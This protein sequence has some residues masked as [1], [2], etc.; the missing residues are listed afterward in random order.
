MLEVVPSDR[1]YLSVRTAHTLRTSEHIRNPLSPIN[2]LVAL[3]QR[4]KPPLTL[5]LLACFTLRN[6]YVWSRNSWRIYIVHTHVLFVFTTPSLHASLAPHPPDGRR[7]FLQVSG[8]KQETHFE[9]W[10]SVIRTCVLAF[11]LRLLVLPLICIKQIVLR[12]L[13]RQEP[14]QPTNC[15]T[16]WRMWDSVSL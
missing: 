2:S 1:D 15:L 5:D 4:T 7:V 8:E 6:S 16:A 12:I 10:S 3:E 13:S 9:P 14:P 11:P